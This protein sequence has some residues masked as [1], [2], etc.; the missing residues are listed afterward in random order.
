MLFEANYF[1]KNRRFWLSKDLVQQGIDL[2]FNSQ[3]PMHLQS[4]TAIQMPKTCSDAN[5]KVHLIWTMY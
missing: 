5:Q 1:K 3:I 4:V 2:S